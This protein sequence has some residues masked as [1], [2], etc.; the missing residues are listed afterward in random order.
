MDKFA[1]LSITKEIIDRD[2]LIW[3]EEAISSWRKIIQI[4]RF[5]TFMQTK[6]YL[7]HR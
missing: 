3:N 2:P 5:D 4:G 7:E 1:A 6:V